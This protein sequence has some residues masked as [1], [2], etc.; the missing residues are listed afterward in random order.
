MTR[1]RI[2]KDER[3]RVSSLCGQTL[4][5]MDVLNH[6]MDDT[7]EVCSQGLPSGGV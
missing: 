2:R 3:T 4:R 7:G 6:N 1:I 5:E